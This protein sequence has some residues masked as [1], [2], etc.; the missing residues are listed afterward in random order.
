MSY[1]QNRFRQNRITDLSRRDR[2]R[3]RLCPRLGFRRRNTEAVCLLRRLDL[4]GR[5]SGDMGRLEGAG[6]DAHA[7]RGDGG[8]DGNYDGSGGC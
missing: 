1:K 6:T 7:R 8:D 5:H 3:G 4:Q 2:Q